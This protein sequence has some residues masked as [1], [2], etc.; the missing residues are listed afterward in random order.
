M[1]N[2]S[3]AKARKTMTKRYTAKPPPTNKN[4]VMQVL[5]SRL[6]SKNKVTA[7]NTFAVPIARYSADVVSWRQEDLKEIKIGTRKLM[8]MDGVF[9]SKSSTTRLY[10]S[11]KEGGRGMHSIDNVVRQK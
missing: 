7:I 9:Y 3:P 11:R 5:R 6:F 2:L 8:T 10:I 1:D 4:R